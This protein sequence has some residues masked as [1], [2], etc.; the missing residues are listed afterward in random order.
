MGM[1]FDGPTK[2]ISLTAGT[3]A[4]GVRDLWSRWV[5]W[6]LTSDNSKYLPAFTQVGGDDIDVSAGTKIPIYAF[7]MNGWKLKPQEADHTLTVSDGILLVN[8][9]GDP[10]NNTSGAYVV[11]INYQQPVQAI[12]FSTSGGGGATAAEVWAYAT[13]SLSGVKQ[14]FDDLNDLTDAQVNAEVDEAI[15]DAA[16]ATAAALATVQGVVDTTKIAV[17]IVEDITRNRLKVNDVSGAVTLYEDDSATLKFTG[18]V[19]DD[20]VNTTRTRLA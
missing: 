12:S 7:L 17:D 14:S 20:S 1:T 5:D 18:S 6:F 8:G 16:L 4:V 10:F 2:V 11:R 19:V 13:R 3:I 15:V 9:G